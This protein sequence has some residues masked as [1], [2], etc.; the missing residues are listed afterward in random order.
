MHTKVITGGADMAET[1]L[2]TVEARFADIIWK[3][4]PLTTA[5]LIKVCAVELN[6]KRTTTYTVL[7]RLEEKGIFQNQDGVVTSQISREDFFA[8]QSGQY[9]EEQFHGSLPAFV[10]AFTRRRSLTDAE[11]EEL[12]RIIQERRQ[13]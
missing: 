1:R 5:E 13:G 10:T 7:K 2:G 4:E 3:M 12:I 8:E 9:V 6:W 11:A